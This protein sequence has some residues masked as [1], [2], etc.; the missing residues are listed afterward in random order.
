MYYLSFVKVYL[1]VTLISLCNILYYHLLINATRYLIKAFIAHNNLMNDVK[2]LLGQRIKEIRKKK[3]LTQEKLAELI[4]IEP[5]NMCF[6]ETGRFYPSPDTVQKIA[7]ALNVKI[8]ELYS[9]DYLRPVHEIKEE[10]F[11]KLE[12]S[13]DLLRM[14]YKICEGLT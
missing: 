2:K 13:E 1:S 5:P 8:Y 4:G 3:G 6:I 11:Q 9:F 7:N 10:L 14:V 12:N